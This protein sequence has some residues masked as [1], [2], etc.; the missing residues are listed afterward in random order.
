MK[1]GGQVALETILVLVFWVVIIF[2]FMNIMFLLSSAM[3]T[4]TGVNRLA[5]Q[6][7]S[8]GCRPSEDDLLRYAE[9]EI[10]GIATEVSRVDVYTWRA[11]SLF[12]EEDFEDT[13]PDITNLV[14]LNDQGIPENAPRLAACSGLPGGQ[15][16]R[17]GDLVYV[18]VEYRQ[19]L[20]L[21]AL[22]GLD[23]GATVYRSATTTSSRIEGGDL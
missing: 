11:P 14:E 9:R 6:V 16:T 10:K 20:L 12:Y 17:L 18:G 19:G 22:F 2:F 5:V 3:L 7:G 1:R 15:E 21:P 23:E 13:N 8:L 4:Q